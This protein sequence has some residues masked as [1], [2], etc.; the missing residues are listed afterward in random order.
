[1]PTQ[2]QP[3]KSF[4]LGRLSELGLTEDEFLHRLGFRKMETGRQHLERLYLGD[5]AQRLLVQRLPEALKSPAAL[6]RNIL[7]GELDRLGRPSTKMLNPEQ[8]RERHKAF[9]DSVGPN[10]GTGMMGKWAWGNAMTEKF[11]QTLRAENTWF[12]SSVSDEY[13]ALRD[14]A[15]V[16]SFLWGDP[17]FISLEGF[18]S[19]VNEVIKQ[20]F[21]ELTHIF[22]LHPKS[23][24]NFYARQ[25]T[26][27]GRILIQRGI[28]IHGKRYS[29]SFCT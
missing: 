8:Y 7:N 13:M 28:I 19:L 29:L 11:H 2:I 14:T 5:R 21:G 1:M 17:D 10:P 9:F 18:N 24:D 27:L 4:I 12:E 3:I 6:V 22:E 26:T 16:Q 25:R 20:A 15:C 23:R